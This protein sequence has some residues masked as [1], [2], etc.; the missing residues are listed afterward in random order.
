MTM[1]M[2]VID[3]ETNTNSSVGDQVYDAVDENV[4]NNNNLA[5]HHQY[6]HGHDYNYSHGDYD[7]EDYHKDNANSDHNNYIDVKGHTKDPD[8]NHKA[9]ALL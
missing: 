6:I 4:D 5:L 1:T 9:D 3:V 2:T 8:H 7:I